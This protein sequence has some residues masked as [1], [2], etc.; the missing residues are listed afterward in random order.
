M[1]F[2]LVAVV[3]MHLQVRWRCAECRYDGGWTLINEHHG[4][5]AERRRMGVIEDLVKINKS[6]Q[7]RGL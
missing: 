2:S 6:V 4:S 7:M 5:D 3:M 1:L